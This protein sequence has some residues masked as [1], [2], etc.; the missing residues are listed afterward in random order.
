VHVGAAPIVEED[1]AV[2]PVVPLRDDP[3]LARGLLQL[4]GRR[5]REG[6]A[7][8]RLLGHQRQGAPLNVH[9]RPLP[10]VVVVLGHE[11]AHGLALLEVAA[12]ADLGVVRVGAPA[13]DELDEAE[14]PGAP[15]RHDALD[16][17]GR[18]RAQ[19]RP[20]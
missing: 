16:P 10:G 14:A 2:A 13:V 12:A 6:H 19:A 1:E 20:R 4:A 9:G 7:L 11:R 8:G 18:P 3:V 15:L 5:L 17:G